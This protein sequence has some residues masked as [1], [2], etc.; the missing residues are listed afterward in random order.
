MFRALLFMVKVGLLVAIAVWVADRPGSVR[1][2]WLEYTFTVHLGLFLLVMLGATLL[3]I[4]LYNV[5]RTFADLPKSY[6]RYLEIRRKDKG[7]RALTLG[8]TAVAAGDTRSAVYQAHRVTKLMP[9][10]KGLPLLL[11]AQAAR[12][13]GREEDARESF[14]AL[15]ESEDAAFLGVRGLLQ[16]ALDMGNY[17][18]ALELARQALKLHPKQPWI[19]STVYELEIRMQDWPSARD[20]LYRAEKAKAIS[21]EKAKSDRVAML[22][23]EADI[24]AKDGRHK[25]AL[26]AVKKAVAIDADFVPA[27]IRFARLSNMEGQ[28][29]PAVKIIERAW[30]INPH[31]EYVQ[32]WEILA[33]QGTTKKPMGRMQWMEKLLE[34]NGES[35]AAQT[36]AGRVAMEQGLWGEARGHL[37]RAEGLEPSARIYRML[38]ELEER[39]GG[40]EE[41]AMTWLEKA[42]AAP[43]A[44]GWVCKQSG[45]IYGQWQPIAQPHGAFNTIAWDFPE[46]PADAGV[47]PRIGDGLLEAPRA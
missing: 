17:T 44:R 11:N 1:I 29:K 13:D 34:V 16:A 22:L 7:Y 38:A 26:K 32:V 23:A 42:S 19:L 8:L 43:P 24:L 28:R 45:R 39:S 25:D 30:K 3:S 46:F 9:G 41:A 33:P 40:S 10:D 14:V 18:K 15:L 6:R 36:E 21:A 27:V 4:F 47:F 37:R 2:E 12:L 35:A 31:P 20:T 5:I